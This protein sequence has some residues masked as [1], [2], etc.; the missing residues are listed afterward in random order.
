LYGGGKTSIPYEL[1]HIRFSRTEQNE[2]DS[3]NDA[4]AIE[5]FFFAEDW[6]VKIEA[7]TTGGEKKCFWR[8]GWWQTTFSVSSHFC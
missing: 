7:V 4:I 3:G 5:P 6:R 1:L 2:Q 8:N